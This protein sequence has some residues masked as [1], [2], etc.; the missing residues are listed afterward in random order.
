[1]ENGKRY[2]E[3]YDERYRQVHDHDLQWA[4]GEPTPIVAQV[5]S[6]FGIT[7]GEAMLELGCG[8]GRDGAFLLSRGYSLLATDIS[9]AA[10]DY[11]RKHDPGHWAQYQ[12]LDCVGGTLEGEYAFIYAIAVLHMLVEDRDR[13]AFYRFIR[14]HLTAD[15]IALIC[16][17]GDGQTEV[18]SDPAAAFDLQ[19]R[20]H[21]QTGQ[22]LLIAG[23]SCRM[24]S[25]GI[26]REELERNGLWVLQE[27][28]TA[29]EPDFNSLMYAV[30]R[31]N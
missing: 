20:Q 6:Q 24:V 23:T 7:T 3:A 27:G 18:C 30:V 10:V 19:E 31:R 1:M 22:T 25:F 9:P 11:C 2:Y 14:E 16:T 26:F 17:M 13:D 15:G 28:I 12:V 8:E 4:S 5:I 21:Q 29:S